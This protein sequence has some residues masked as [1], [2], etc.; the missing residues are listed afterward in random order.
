VQR[1]DRS[2]LRSTAL[3]T[4]CRTRPRKYL[5]PRFIRGGQYGGG[6]G[7]GRGL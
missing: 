6:A 4:K 7:Q 1:S 5:Q 2:H 3:R